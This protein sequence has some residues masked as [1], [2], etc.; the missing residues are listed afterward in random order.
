MPHQGTGGN[1]SNNTTKRVIDFNEV[2]AQKLEEKRRK[3]ER[4]FFKSLLS[5]YSLVG[6]TKMLPIELIDVSEEGLSFQIPHDP[7]NKWPKDADEEIPLRLYFSQDTF[8]EIRA[9]IQ[10][11][12][13]SIESNARYTRFGCS[14][15]QKTASYPAY[16]QFVRFMKSYAEQSKKDTGGVSVFY[17]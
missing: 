8:L 15:D 2:R 16:Q 7:E 4:V 11:S 9:K 14:I 13:P 10:N 17:L 3:T 5:V 12:R 6:D 1:S